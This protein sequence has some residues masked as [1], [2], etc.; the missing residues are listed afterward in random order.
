MRVHS[1]VEKASEQGLVKGVGDDNDALQS[2][3]SQRDGRAEV[4]VVLER[5]VCA[6][7]IKA[8]DKRRRVIVRP[9]RVRVRKS[10]R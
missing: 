6:A 4:G 2:P 8:S 5:R 1:P 3:S 10:R 7:H 9:C